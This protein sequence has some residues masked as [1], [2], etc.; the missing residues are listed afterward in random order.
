MPQQGSRAGVTGQEH[1]RAVAADVLQVDVGLAF[2]V[3]VGLDD[4]DGHASGSPRGRRGSPAGRANNRGRKKPEDCERGR[5]LP[6]RCPA[7]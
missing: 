7:G 1:K 6:H 5:L 2:A 4:G 3:V